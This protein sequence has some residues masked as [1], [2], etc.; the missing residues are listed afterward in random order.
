MVEF[1]RSHGL[2]ESNVNCPVNTLYNILTTNNNTTTIT[3]LILRWADFRHN[4]SISAVFKM[5]WDI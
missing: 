3:G 4:S 5:L 1:D 2:N